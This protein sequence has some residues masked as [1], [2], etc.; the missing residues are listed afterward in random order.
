LLVRQK[1][2]EIAAERRVPGLEREARVELARGEGMADCAVAYLLAVTEDPAGTMSELLQG[3]SQVAEAAIHAPGGSQMREAIQRNSIQMDWIDR[4]AADPDPRRRHLA[5]AGLALMEDRGA[6]AL[7]RLLGDSDREVRREA[8]RTAGKLRLPDLVN[9]LLPL[10]AKPGVRAEALEALA[11]YGDDVCGPLSDLLG[12]DSVSPAIRVQVPRALKLIR[13]QRSVDALVAAIGHGNLAVRASVLKALNSLRINAPKL[14]FHQNFVNEYILVEA[15][16]YFELNAALASFIDYRKPGSAAGLLARTIEQR[17]SDSIERLFR[18]L[19][20]RYPPGEIYS[21]YLA[22][23]SRRGEELSTALE[24]LDN[25]LDKDLKRVVLPMLDEPDHVHEMGRRLF[26][27]ER[28]DAEP[29]IRELIAS[30]D[31][32]LVAC[33]ISAARELK[34]NGLRSDIVAAS[35]RAD[36]SVGRVADQALEALA[37]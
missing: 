20:L 34:L 15:R 14:D 32:W 23:K 30:D 6:A 17:L 16:G 29:A 12:D 21:A 31:P 26:G 28:R 36:E 9:T 10:V 13:T 7:Q 2:Y 19:G 8:V 3:S 22:Y 1:V 4:A 5:A 25:T 27:F 37:S 33:A 18:L 35:K 11:A 24:F